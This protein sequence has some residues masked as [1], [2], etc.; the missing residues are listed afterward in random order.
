[1][2]RALATAYYRLTRTVDER[3]KPVTPEMDHEEVV[4]YFKELAPFMA[5]AH[6]EGQPMAQDWCLS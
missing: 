1:M 4:A 3:D 5:R 2:L 6:Q